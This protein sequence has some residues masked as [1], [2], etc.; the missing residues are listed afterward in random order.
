MK[1][2]IRELKELLEELQDLE[3]R[4]DYMVEAWNLGDECDQAE[5]DPGL[6]F[7]LGEEISAKIEEIKKLCFKIGTSDGKS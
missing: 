7:E 2:Q 4:A 3:T 6:Q 1:E 5:N